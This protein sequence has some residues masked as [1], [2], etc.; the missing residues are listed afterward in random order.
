MF[1]HIPNLLTLSRMAATPVMVLLLEDGAYETALLLFLVAGITDGLD[2]YIAKHYK[3]ES[4][5]GAILDPL[6]DKMLIVC[7]Y[8]MLAMLGDIP[9]WLFVIVM[10]RDVLIIGGYLILATLK[11]DVRISPSVFSK[12]NTF[13]QITLVLAVLVDRTGWIPVGPLTGV[14]VVCVTAT[15]IFSGAHYVWRWGI[16]EEGRRPD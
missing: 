12:V 14:L 5:L 3:W 6:A 13:L 10:F 11:E 8:V 16:Q 7:T 1:A 4:R 9:F 2:G 15:T